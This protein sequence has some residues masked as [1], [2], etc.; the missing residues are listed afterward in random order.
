MFLVAPPGLYSSCVFVKVYAAPIPMIQ[1]MISNH[2]KWLGIGG[3]ESH[4]TEK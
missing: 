2:L 1:Q 4:F 3:R